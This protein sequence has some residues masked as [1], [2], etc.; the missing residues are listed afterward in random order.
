MS[1]FCASLCR[2]GVKLRITD[3]DQ[4]H[5]HADLQSMRIVTRASLLATESP[6]SSCAGKRTADWNVVF[7]IPG[8]S[9]GAPYAPSPPECGDNDEQR[10]SC[11]GKPRRG[12]EAGGGSGMS[13]PKTTLGSVI[14]PRPQ[15]GSPPWGGR[16][17]GE[18]QARMAAHAPSPCR[19]GRTA[20]ACISP[21]AF[22]PWR[23]G[24]P[25]SC[26]PLPHA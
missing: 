21:P 19:A 5:I 6:S 3:V 1:I 18:A 13:R 17:P 16:P 2:K 7:R 20:P 9:R 15:A 4:E 23:R 10:G 8:R 12:Q 22:L 26:C 25:A 24:R 11:Q 14:E